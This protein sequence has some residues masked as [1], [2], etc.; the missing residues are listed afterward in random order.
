MLKKRKI[1]MSKIQFLKCE[2]LLLF[3]FD[4]ESFAPE[5]GIKIN[6]N[7]KLIFFLCFVNQTAI[8]TI[9]KHSH[10]ETIPQTE[11]MLVDCM[12]AFTHYHLILHPTKASTINFSFTQTADEVRSFLTFTPFVLRFNIIIKKN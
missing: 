9:F 3:L 2:L 7:N 8:A 11:T 10:T 6:N 4:F 1:N 5:K 12:N